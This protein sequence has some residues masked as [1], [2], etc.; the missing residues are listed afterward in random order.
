MSEESY[1]DMILTARMQALI[2]QTLYLGEDACR[3]LARSCGA[4][5]HMF[6]CANTAACSFVFADHVHVVFCG[7][8]DIADWA[9][10]L[11]T[12]AT[13]IGNVSA[14]S[15]FTNQAKWIVDEMMSTTLPLRIRNKTIFLGGHS[16]GGAIAEIAPLVDSRLAN[17]HSIYTF[18]SPRSITRD[19]VVRYLQYPWKTHR[20]VMGGDPVPHV[21]LSVAV[22]IFGRPAYAHGYLGIYLSDDGKLRSASGLSVVGKAIAIARGIYLTGLTSLAVFVRQVPSLLRAHSVDRYCNGIC[23]APDLL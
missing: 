8:N 10:N 7:T 21:P 1:R 3:K 17:V 6:S 20:F 9:H 4:E 5:C 14:H 12:K 11:D 15:G 19:S 16:A 13:A 2:A 22:V 23:K 18:G